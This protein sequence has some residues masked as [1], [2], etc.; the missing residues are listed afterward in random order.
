VNALFIGGII[1]KKRK[2]NARI[3]YTGVNMS[4][5]TL[6]YASYGRWALVLCKV[7][8]TLWWGYMS[9]FI[10]KFSFIHDHVSNVLNGILMYAFHEGFDVSFGDFKVG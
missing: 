7:I 1:E 10:V 4:P 9:L 6:C 8:S 2:D 5:L 3:M